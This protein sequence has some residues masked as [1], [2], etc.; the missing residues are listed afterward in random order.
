MDRT[1]AVTQHFSTQE[2][3]KKKKKV[4]SECH[5]HIDVLRVLCCYACVF[6]YGPFYCD[7]FRPVYILHCLQHFF[8]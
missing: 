2:I 8:F 4:Y 5:L 7:A 3:Y 6:V 1:K